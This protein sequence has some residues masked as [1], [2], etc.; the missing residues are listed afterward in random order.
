MHIYHYFIAISMSCAAL[1]MELNVKLNVKKPTEY[2]LVIYLLKTRAPDKIPDLFAKLPQNIR[3]DVFRELIPNYDLFKKCNDASLKACKLLELEARDHERQFKSSTTLPTSS[4]PMLQPWTI[5]TNSYEW[6]PDRITPFRENSNLCYEKR[7]KNTSRTGYKGIR[8]FD[9]ITHKDYKT[10][11]PLLR[12]TIYPLPKYTYNDSR[13]QKE[14]RIL[15]GSYIEGESC[16]SATIDIHW[17]QER[18]SGHEIQYYSPINRQESV[19]IDEALAHYIAYEIQ[20]INI[21]YYKKAYD[22]HYKKHDFLEKECS[23]LD[24]IVALSSTL[25]YDNV[26]FLNNLLMR[27]NYTEE[28]ANKTKTML[29]SKEYEK[30]I[31]MPKDVLKIITRCD[32]ITHENL[33]NA[34]NMVLDYPLETPLLSCRL[35]IKP[36]KINKNRTEE[37]RLKAHK[38]AIMEMQGHEYRNTTI[39]LIDAITAYK[40]GCIVS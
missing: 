23:T 38:H 1:A 20:K 26:I 2:D 3:K 11:I 34:M 33:E 16:F 39:G 5:R 30:I 8:I 25:S 6:V 35:I 40:D 27:R 36:S 18:R 22:N 9:L 31:R 19:S 37:E 32:F 29:T 21:L 24:T 12:Q 13:L 28:I 14:S 7:T 17:P 10:P 4:M 15:L